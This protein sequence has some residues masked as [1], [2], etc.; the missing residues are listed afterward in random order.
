MQKQGVLLCHLDE[1][2]DGSSK[3]FLPDELGNDTVFLVRRGEQIFAYS[4]IC[5][6]YGDT[7]L[8]WKKD[9]YLDAAREHIVCAAHGALFD[10]ETGEC[11]QGPC[12]GEFL[13][14]LNITVSPAGEVTLL[15]EQ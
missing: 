13:R 3:G 1:L 9:V 15:S 5:P 10:T 14:P 2:P 8:P 4:D 12:R 6:H 11:V 7:A